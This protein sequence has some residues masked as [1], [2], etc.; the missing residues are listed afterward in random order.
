[1]NQQTAGDGRARGCVALAVM[2]IWVPVTLA[3]DVIFGYGLFFQCRAWAFAEVPGAV[4]SSRLAGE[5][6]APHLDVRYRYAVDGR[7]FVGDRYCYGMFGTNDGTWQRVQK[8]LP[9]GTAVPVY[10]NPADPGEAT[11]TRGPQGMHLF[12]GN[13]L[14]PFNMVIIGVVASRLGRR[15]EGSWQFAAR[16][17]CMSAAT[18]WGLVSFACIFAF[19]LFV[20]FNPPVWVGAIPWV[21]GLT[22]GLAAAAGVFRLVSRS[23]TTPEA[24]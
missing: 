9:A 18:V 22:L 21:V 24:K 6:D 20:G 16:W 12:L 15:R 19:G 5:S 3:F 14:V 1:M 2:C 8:G 7:E 13:F 23:E 10:Y 17:G 4:T 11:L